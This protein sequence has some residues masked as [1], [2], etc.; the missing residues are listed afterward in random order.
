MAMT[1]N[2]PT[3]FVDQ[4][5]GIMRI[6]DQGISRLRD[7]TVNPKSLQNLSE[8]LLGPRGATGIVDVYVPEYPDT[9]K[10]LEKLLPIAFGR[11]GLQDPSK[12][13]QGDIAKP[14]VDDITGGVR[15]VNVKPAVDNDG[16]MERLRRIRNIANRDK[17]PW[18]DIDPSDPIF[19]GFSEGEVKDAYNWNEHD[20][21]GDELADYNHAYDE[22]MHQLGE[23]TNRILKLLQSTFGTTSPMVRGRRITP[24]KPSNWKEFLDI[25]RKI[26]KGGGGR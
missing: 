1:S 25:Y 23:E 26:G 12:G 5:R 7:S 14:A 17:R 18:D 4:I 3:N 13:V 8:Q 15:S 19:R 24:E 9:T 20:I 2:N 22:R 21:D 11:Q 16:Y 6:R 10:V